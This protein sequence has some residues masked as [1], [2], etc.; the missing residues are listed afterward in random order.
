MSLEKRIEELTV[1]VTLLTRAIT[2]AET[3]KGSKF[4]LNPYE[5]VLANKQAR[6][7]EDNT[8]VAVTPSDIE[9]APSPDEAGK[10]TEVSYA[11]MREE[12]PMLCR[13]IMD[14]SRADKPKVQEAFATFNG[15][16]SLSEICDKDL[17]TLLSKLNIIKKEQ[18]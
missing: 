9:E 16:K 3:S 12:I 18:K 13:D 10:A 5:K 8:L 17:P 11:D 15:A 7:E 1:A 6:E 2:I 4:D 14:K